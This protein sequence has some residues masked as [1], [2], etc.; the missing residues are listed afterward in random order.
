MDWD[1]G[2]AIAFIAQNLK[3]ESEPLTIFLGDD[4]TD[5]DGFHM[6]DNSGGISIYVGEEGT[7]SVA[8]YLLCSPKETYQF[9]NML[10]ETLKLGDS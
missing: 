7:E 1:K 5:Y 10:R 6:V 4:I 2:K 8:Q 9:L 3:G